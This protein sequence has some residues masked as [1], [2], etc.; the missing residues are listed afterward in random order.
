MIGET[1][2]MGITSEASDEGLTSRGESNT[3]FTYEPD[4]IEDESN[5]N[6]VNTFDTNSDTDSSFS[7]HKIDGNSIFGLKFN[8]LDD[9]TQDKIEK[10]VEKLE[11][12]IADRMSMFD[13]IG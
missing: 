1:N 9:V 5:Q 4:L 7:N 13:L 11:D 2:N 8:G 10:R 6:Q 3:F 12:R